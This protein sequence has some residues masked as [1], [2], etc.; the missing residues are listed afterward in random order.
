MLH[1]VPLKKTINERKVFI[2]Y[3]IPIVMS[4][5]KNSDDLVDRRW[6]LEDSLLNTKPEL[7]D[8]QIAIGLEVY[9]YMIAAK[10]DYEFKEKQNHFKTA[11][12][13]IVNPKLK[14]YS[15]EFQKAIKYLL[16]SKGIINENN[17]TEILE[18]IVLT[19][20]NPA[21]N[22]E[23]YEFRKSFKNYAE[24]NII[25][26]QRKPGIIFVLGFIKGNP[27]HDFYVSDGLN[28][29]QLGYD[30]IGRNLFEDDD[31]LKENIV[32]LFYRDGAIVLDPEATIIRARTH[33]INL[34]DDEV[35]QYLGVPKLTAQNMG[36]KR[37]VD[38]RHEAI[39]KSS[40]FLKDL[41]HYALSEES[42][43]V[44][45]CINGKIMFSTNR[46]E[47][48]DARKRLELSLDMY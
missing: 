47:N 13:L 25:Q 1:Y 4:G 26:N 28:N 20:K 48:Y 15:P 39:I 44:T 8:L 2:Q 19:I 42:G 35:A 34:K 38:T 40:Y 33:L 37:S 36:F 31:K 43:D 10:N 18:T 24:A 29:E 5:F 30:I 11:E 3:K 32:K 45:R 21:S 22:Q 17:A 12:P 16:D 41:S 14:R 27:Q 7:K 23:S 46:E 9:N 6:F